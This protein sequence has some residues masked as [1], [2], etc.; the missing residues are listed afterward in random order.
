MSTQLLAPARPQQLLL[1]LIFPGQDVHTDTETGTGTDTG[2]A[3]TP[4]PA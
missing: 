4:V 2:E 3:A 1:P